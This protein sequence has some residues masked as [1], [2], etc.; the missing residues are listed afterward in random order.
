M[1]SRPKDEACFFDGRA[2]LFP[3]VRHIDNR[4]KLAPFSFDELPFTPSRCFTISDV[5]AGE[6]RGQHAHRSGRQMLVCLQG[7]IEV[8][9]RYQ[10]EEVKLILNSLSPAV[11]FDAGVW[12]QQTYL[13]EKSVL[14]VFA[15]EAYNP[16]SYIP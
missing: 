9:M 11:I 12:C 2:R 10:T 14:L 5:T 16:D 6:V 7:S 13:D 3:C 1:A 15:S 8:L 4:G